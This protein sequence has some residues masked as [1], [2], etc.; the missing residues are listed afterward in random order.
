MRT[1]EQLEK[2]KSN[3]E[4]CSNYYALMKYNK[5]YYE[6]HSNELKPFKF[7][8]IFCNSYF[9]TECAEK[10]RK[11][12]IERFEKFRR[13]DSWRFLTLTLRNSGTNTAENLKNFSRYFNNFMTTI[14][15]KN[16]GIKYLS[17]IEIGK[18]GNVHAHILINRYL[19]QKEVSRLWQKASGSYIVHI[20]KVYNA[21]SCKRYISKYISKFQQFEETNDLFYLMQV[22]RVS[23]SQNFEKIIKSSFLEMLADHKLMS[24]E[25]IKEFIILCKTVNCDLSNYDFSSLPPPFIESELSFLKTK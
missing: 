14:R 20:E 10:K 5:Y 18:S 24:L 3:V 9:C 23:W 6:L 13:S 25:K 4:K 21:Q 12:I 8:P 16:P 1:R 2:H 11:A 22:K 15:K 17:V 19:Q 7:V